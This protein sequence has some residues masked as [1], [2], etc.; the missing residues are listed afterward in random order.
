MLQRPRFKPHYHVE[1][2]EGEG[3]FVLSE[4]EQTVLQGRLYEQ[5]VPLLDG[6]PVEDL[7]ACLSP[8]LSPARVFYTL[9]R[10]EQKN[11]LCE[12]DETV[13]ADQAALWSLQ[14]LGPATAASLLAATPV[15]ALGVGVAVEPLRELLDSL[16]VRLADDGE[17]RV[18]AADHYLRRE[19][20]S[21]NEVALRVG[22]PWLLVKP[23]GAQVWLG[24]L[25]VPGQTGCWECLARRLRANCP[26]L[27]YLDQLRAAT[28][29]P[30]VFRGQ[31]PATQAVAWGLVAH[32]VASWV[33]HGKVSAVLEGKLQTLDLHAGE[34]RTHSLLRHPACPACGHADGRAGRAGQPVVLES[35]TKT[36]TE[37]GGHRAQSPQ[38]TL[39]RFGHLVSPICGAVTMLKPVAPA[40]ADA[41]HVYV[42]GHNVARTP[43]SL[44]HL[45]VDLRNASCGKGTSALQARASALC[46]GLERYSGQFQGDEPRRRARLRELAGDG[47]H[48]NACMLFSEAQY[49]KRQ[50]EN[51]RGA[52]FHRVPC[53]FDPDAR[54]EWTPV[55][56]LTR[57]R[58]R[59][60]PTGFCYF[61]YPRPDEEDFCVGCSNGNAA[62]N[63]LEEAI[64]QGFLELVER[65]SV[66]LWW[67]NR[68]AVPGVDLDSFHEPYLT[69]LRDCLE[70]YGRDLWALDLTSDLGIPVY[71]AV[72]R[73]AGGAA[74]QILF[75][76]G[77]H[78]DPRIA[79]LRSVTELNQMLAP[80]LDT[81]PDSPP[82][83]LTDEDTL[84]WLRT[85]RLDEHRYLAPRDGPPRT[86]ADHPRVWGEDLKEDVLWCRS[87]A[88][89]IGLEVLVLD[90]TRP[91]IG[92]PVVKVIVPGLRH[93]WPRFAPGR[94]YDVPVKL[95]WVAAPGTEEQLNPIPMFL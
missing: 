10:L 64:L 26:V 38:E 90:Q 35:R 5:V 62:G 3:V 94:L 84:E 89:A 76:F 65:D 14:G 39:D 37:D 40:G 24:P 42:S 29:L 95:G 54:I 32:A 34:M 33:A 20:R 45:K 8:P 19:L 1:V 30:A 53:P 68:A 59:Y 92:L 86:A 31:S 75:G 70:K 61:D 58:V 91:E 74:E 93:F 21:I 55:W 11:Y 77:A 44:H 6:R 49:R 12:A 46:E 81:P 15:S 36:Y 51:V 57:E 9:N 50:E 88:E 83:D 66:A 2:I 28:G 43:G 82:K 4:T 80:L 87:R 78:L 22:Q 27:G 69:R 18:V 23:A 63:T 85:A 48:P 16:G 47:L 60:L 79:L 7:C 71:A 56:S 41:L 25:F 17:L 72:S 13:P 67:Y 52:I 73:R